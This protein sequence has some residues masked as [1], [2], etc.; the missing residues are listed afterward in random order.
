MKLRVVKNSHFSARYL[1]THNAD[2]ARH[3]I[4]EKRIMPLVQALATAVSY[5]RPDDPVEFMKQILTDLKKAR[6]ENAPI[7]IC[8]TEENIKSMFSVLDPFGKG[9][10]TRPQM[11]G[12]L[13]NFGTE[14]DVIGEVLG[15]D[16][17]PF[18]VDKFAKLI[19]AGVRQ[20]LFPSK[21]E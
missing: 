11:E 14:H 13:T 4:Q 5:S 16:Q 12:A 17:G 15:D 9:T 3:Y 1:M 7:L 18:D 19:H 6:D 2:S 21:A 8:F 20:T 10:I